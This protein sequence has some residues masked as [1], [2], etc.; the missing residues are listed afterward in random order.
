MVEAL[1]SAHQ[2]G[3]SADGEKL[4]GNVAAHA[5]SFATGYDDDIVG[6][7]MRCL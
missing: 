5:Q 4:F 1:D 2:H 7:P 3:F 6:H